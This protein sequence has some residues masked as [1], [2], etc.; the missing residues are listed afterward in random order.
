MEVKEAIV[1]VTGASS[2][3]G[4]ATALAFDREGARVSVA[5][6]RQARVEAIAN[7]MRAALVLPTDLSAPGQAA[8]MVKKTLQHFGRL[9]VLINNAGVA[10][11]T[12]SDSLDPENTRQVMETNLVGAMIATR[13]ALP[14]MLKQ[15]YGHIINICSPAGFLGVPLM[16]DYCASKA[17]MSGW[18]RALQAEWLGTAINVTEYLPGLIDTELGQSRDETAAS[19]SRAS[20]GGTGP[21]AALSPDRVADQLV[22][23]VRRPRQV[24][25]S[26]FGARVM[27]WVMESARFRRS[28]GSRIGRAQRKHL[29]LPIFTIGRDD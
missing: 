19:P 3:I 14:S 8:S 22:A 5:A 17:A 13:E 26:S 7:G 10:T 15:G 23:C 20:D 1:L 11:P 27:C 25:Y 12:N 24:M 9:D 2:G 16:A 28:V 29:G 21:L 6:R 18:T 4:R